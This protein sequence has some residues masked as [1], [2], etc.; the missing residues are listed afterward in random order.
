MTQ[1]EQ[2]KSEGRGKCCVTSLL[3]KIIDS[4]TA[5][6]TF[7][8]MEIKNMSI[9]RPRNYHANSNIQNGLLFTI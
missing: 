5:R 4:D 6:K 2:A 8:K 7:Y 9:V 1:F 3:L